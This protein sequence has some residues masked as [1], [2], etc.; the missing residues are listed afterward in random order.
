MPKKTT[1][2]YMTRKNLLKCSLTLSFSNKQNE[3]DEP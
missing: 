2:I 3:Q 1:P